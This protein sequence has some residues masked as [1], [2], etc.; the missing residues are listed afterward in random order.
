MTI[1]EAKKKLIT[2]V[3]SQIGY[4]EGADNYTKYADDPRI[5][6]LYGWNVQNQPWCCTFVNW[7][8]LE[9]FGERIG[10]RMT[11]GGSAACANQAG[12]YKVAGAWF[13]VPE[14][15]DQVFFYSGGSINHTG[16]VT[17]V[18]G[19]SIQTVEGNY[20]DKVSQATY[21][22]GNKVIAGFGR[23]KWRLTEEIPTGEPAAAPATA[24]KKTE[25]HS[26]TP[27]VLSRT[28]NR[29]G[30]C[31]VLQ[32]LLN[33]HGFDC[34]S[35]GIDGYFGKDTQTAV[36][37]A[38]MFYGLNADGTCDSELWSRLMKMEGGF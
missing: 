30:A 1:E 31:F 3:K 28:V 35:A 23:P 36:N 18:N 10:T 8:F 33:V 7:C 24:P 11:C 9:A 32:A 4:R 12:Y 13:Q 14:A 22:L 20:S 17:E 34:G 6:K 15:G 19:T 5:T 25:D 2:L 27:P 26:W 29:T 16:I 21:I 38:K 37:A